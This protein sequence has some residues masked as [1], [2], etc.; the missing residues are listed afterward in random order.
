[1]L[2]KSAELCTEKLD[3]IY[4]E[5]AKLYHSEGKYNE[6]QI[7]LEKSLAF[8]PNQFDVLIELAWM[9]Y[10]KGNKSKVDECM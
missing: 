1:M 7:V 8:N 10:M 6:E 4:F 3:D 5:L 2:E 9:Y